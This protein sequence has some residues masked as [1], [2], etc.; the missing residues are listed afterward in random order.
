[1]ARPRRTDGIAVPLPNGRYKIRIDLP[2][3]G[4]RWKTLSRTMP[5]AEARALSVE[6]T[7]RVAANPAAAAAILG[8]DLAEGAPG[9]TVSK[10]FGRWIQDRERR[11]I[12]S[13]SD[14]RSRFRDHVEPVLGP[15]P[16]ANIGRDDVRDI[17]RKL[18][19]KVQAGAIRWK[20]ADHV[21]ILVRG[22][23][24]SA[25]GSKVPELVVRDDDPTDRVS[26]PDRGDDLARTYLY[27]S[28]FVRLVSCPDVPVYWRRL[29]ALAAYTLSRAGELAALRWDAVDLERG[30]IHFRQ[31][32]D[33][34]GAGRVKSTKSGVARRVPIEPNLRPL[35]EALKKEATDDR[36]FH[37]QVSKRADKLRAHLL[38]AGLTRA[39]LHAPPKDDPNVAATWAPLTFHDLRGT[40]VTWMALRGDE[41]LVIQ[42]RAGHKDFATSQRY[43]REAEALGSDATE[44]FPPL[45]AELLT[46]GES[47]RVSIRGELSTRNDGAGH[48]VRTRDPELGKLVLYQLS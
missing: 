15:K 28:E 36:V 23:F 5:E 44:P 11:G 8:G 24:K 35:L 39:E 41:P 47:I 3:G 38:A 30:V 6:L 48:G 26:P 21:W 25:C 32:A 33:R 10:Y 9:E 18:D 7:A 13:V 40:G 27:P 42:Q 45:P 2:G 31:A 14:D 37:V 16:I 1:M 12:V 22:I 19:G 17:V 20:T 4:C 43:L 46:P 29:Y 34:R